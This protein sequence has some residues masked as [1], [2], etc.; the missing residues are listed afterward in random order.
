[1]ASSLDSQK[2]GSKMKIKSYDHDP[3]ATTAVICS[4]DGGTTKNI[5]DMRDY[6]GFMVVAKPTVVGGGG[7]T[8]L[9]IVGFISTDSTGAGTAYVIKD[10]GTVAAD[11]LD[12]NVVEECT[13]AEIAQ[14]ATDAGVTLRYV[15]AR[16]TNATNTDEVAVTYV[17]YPAK[18]ATA[19][20]TVTAIA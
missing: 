13:A 5:A 10:S 12:D 16:L 4:A 2:I 7:L 15:A 6:D 11:A 20:L 3:G 14:V 17:Q 9:E 1:M 18:R 19:D 8:K